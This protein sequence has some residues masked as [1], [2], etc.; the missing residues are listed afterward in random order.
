MSEPASPL[1]GSG[2]P[3][4]PR[5]LLR[6]RSYLLL[7]VMG[8]IVGVPV[9]FVAYWFLKI[10]AD[11]QQW[12]FQTLPLDLGFAAPPAWWPVPVLFV[13]GLGV[14][15]AIHFLPGTGGHEP[16]LGFVNSGAPDAIELP[17]IVVAAFVSLGLGAVVGPEAPLIAIGGGLAVLIVRLIARNAP[18]QAAVVIGAAGSFAAV[19]TLLGSPLLGAFLLMEIAGVAGPMV[20]VVLVPGLLAAGIGS[21]VFLGLDDL[22]G[23]GTFSLAIPNLPAFDSIT[24]GQLGWAIAIGLVGAVLGTVIKRGSLLLAPVVAKRRLLVTPVVGAAVG[25]AAVVFAQGA[26][27]GTDLVLFSGQDALPGLIDGA[28]GWTVG[29]LVLLVLCK[30]VAYSLSLSS[31]RGGPIFPAMFIGAAVGMA[32]SHLPGLPMVAGV[33]MG[34]GAMAVTMLGLPLT[35]VLL[36]AVFLQT[37]GVQLTPLIIVAVTVAYV[38]SAR[39]EPRAAAAG[40]APDSPTAPAPTPAGG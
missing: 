9:A 13:A 22:T 36:T 6:E 39:L 20:G 16:S 7:L 38:A 12:I 1:A 21:L 2:A 11:A 28:A 35:S 25:G 15:A 17:G 26:D 24:I 33:A 27:R 18:A 4:D 32:M 34:I 30:S 5:A 14:A 37:D 40:D 8:A 23:Y 3:T 19:A 29:A 10:V 31:F